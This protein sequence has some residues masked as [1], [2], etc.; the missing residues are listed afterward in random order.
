M[1]RL[2]PS[3]CLLLFFSASIAQSIR[4]TESR[5]SASI[6]ESSS[7]LVDKPGLT[8]TIDSLLKH[9]DHY[10]FVPL[11][12]ES[13]NAPMNRE[14]WVRFVVQTAVPTTVYVGTDLSL[15]APVNLYQVEGNQ[16]TGKHSLGPPHKELFWVKA[17]FKSTRIAEVTLQ[18][19]K[20]YTFYWQSSSLPASVRIIPSQELTTFF[21][22]EDLFG[23]FYYGFALIIILYN[24]LLFAQLRDPDHLT[25]AVWVA[26]LGVNY[27]ILEG[28]FNEWM[29]AYFSL[30]KRHFLSITFLSS[31]DHVL[32]ALLFLQVSQRSRLLWRLGL[33][34][35]GALVVGALC[36]VFVTNQ[37]SLF[38]L[39]CSF[40]GALLDLLFSVLAGIVAI[41]QGF[42]PGWY[43]LLGILLIW[44]GAGYAM[45]PFPYTFTKA[46]SV[47][48]ASIAEIVVF[49]LALS[50]KVN[51]LKKQRENA[52]D[53]QLALAQLN[54]QLIER[55][56]R[57]LEEK[58][59]QRTTQLQESLTTL[60][61]TQSQ[62][63]QQEKLASLGE[64]T[65]GI[66]HEIQNPLN[67]VNNFSEVST[68]LVDELKEGPFQKLPDTDKE[69]AEEILSDLTQ[70]LQKITHHGGR[71]SAIVKGM[72]E[73][74]RIGTGEKQSTNLNAVAEEYLR[75][76][77]HGFKSKDKNFNCQLITGFATDLP[78]VSVVAQDIGRV[79]LNL[80][81]NAFYAVSQRVMQAQSGYAPMVWVSTRKEPGRLLLCVRDNGTGISE[82]IHD[83]IFQPFFTTKPTG[84][85]TGLGL[86]LSYDIVTKGHG[87]SLTVESQE[88][89]GTK[90]VIQ[91]PALS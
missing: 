36:N 15:L 37:D 19:S 6:L 87:G 41:R 79:L 85:G 26:L 66:A 91:L 59:E 48:L 72:L 69:Y 25:Y 20:R 71:A 61:A 73:H 14:R 13:T 77:Y 89:E 5:Q 21:L 62:L 24:L 60:R 86:S 10:R 17:Q 30:F 32:F 56:N 18:P 52:I 53:Q 28:Y 65:A 51:L 63:I 3:F 50:Y 57:E 8:V 9:P 43:F 22:M 46:Y 45:G 88:G 1:K 90:F 40:A 82:T 74:S 44:L 54:Q 11:G 35:I 12:K 78:T 31:A 58:V 29:P 42:K 27:G 68:E 76:A 75:L 34:I 67:F 70:N 83:K 64:L 80:Y 2:I 16:L 47:M 39:L 38:T 84:D 49:T 23:G 33:A 4:L 81:N 55:Q 7:V